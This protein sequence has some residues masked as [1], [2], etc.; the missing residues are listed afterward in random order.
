MLRLRKPYLLF[1]GDVQDKLTAKTAFGLKDWCPDDVMGEWS[2]P[3]CRVTL[4][5]PR[6]SPQEAGRRGAGSIIVGIA[7]TGG[8]LPPHWLAELKAAADAG[9]DVVSGLHT[10][11]TSIAELVQAAAR[12]AVR[13][14]DVRYGEKTY[15][16]ASGRKR[17]GKRLLTVGTDCALGKKYTA[18]ALAQNLRKRGVA[19]SFRATGQTGI[20]ISGEGIAIDAVI[21]DFIA[22][23]AEQ[24]SPD[25]AADH[26]DV[27]EGQGS[28][29]HPA[30][31]GVT[32]GLLHGSQPDLIV[33]CH[34]PSR[35]T[36]DEYPDFP[37]PDLKTAI[38]DYLRAGRLTNPAIRCVGLSINSSSLTD[39]ECAAYFGRLN[40]ELGLP[41]CDPVRTGVDVLAAA[42]LAAAVLAT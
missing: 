1:L 25:N 32:L 37:I 30:Y 17:S 4:G 6:L 9:L 20:M 18:L 8:A 38:D 26:W 27:I 23:A 5:L 21:A 12:R 3:G 14:I 34:D 7:P 29:F 36:I 31:A 15:G 42:V 2:L 40:L 33:L 16:A 24:L 41:V 39:S 22:G 11:L 28:L 13:L 19:A 10:R 35:R